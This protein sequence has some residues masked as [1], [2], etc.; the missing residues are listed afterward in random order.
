MN[1]RSNLA[2]RTALVTGA[3]SGIGRAIAVELAELGAHVVLVGRREKPLVETALLVSQRRGKA[4]CLAHDVRSAE[5]LRAVEAHTP[6][7][8]VVVNNAPAFATFGP[9]EQLDEG[10]IDGVFAT[11][12]RAPLAILKRVLPGMKQRGFGRIVNV[13]SISADAGADGQVVYGTA[14]SALAGLT[15]S[16]AAETARDGITCNLVLPGLIA[17]ERVAAKIPDELQRRILAATAIGRAGT[18]EEVAHAVAFLC[19]PGA[20]YITGATLEVTG[21]FHAGMYARDPDEV[22]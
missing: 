20:S 15:R 13:G 7:F 19:T 4:T 11:I 21:G 8:D 17:T 5:F 18:P 12:V 2:G 1:A 14:K 3:G 10:E 9:L 6:G 22:R 16:V